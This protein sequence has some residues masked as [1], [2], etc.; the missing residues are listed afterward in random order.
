MVVSATAIVTA[1][2]RRILAMGASASAS[3]FILVMGMN[4]IVFHL[5]FPR[6]F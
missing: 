5:F 2:I 1:G 3:R 6:F 4:L